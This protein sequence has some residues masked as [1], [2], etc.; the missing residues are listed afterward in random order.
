M[1][2]QAPGN[3]SAM[4]DRPRAVLFDAGGTLVLQHHVEMGERLAFVI[5][6]ESAFD[7]HYRTM[8]EFAEIL[9]TGGATS[10]AWFLEQYFRRLGHPRPS[11][12]GPLIDNGYLLWSWPLPGIGEAVERISAAGIRVA[13]ISNS[14]GSVEQ[15]LQR[16]GLADLFEFILD[17]TVVGAKKPDPAIFTLACERL[18]IA[19]GDT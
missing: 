11:E 5:E 13:V 15:S 12:A 10:W 4:T 6:P 17:S 1:G 2:V 8:A 18:G 19:S 14:D 7:A 16:A 9:D 3:V